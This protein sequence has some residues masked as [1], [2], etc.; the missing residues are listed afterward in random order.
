MGDVIK[1]RDKYEAL[2]TLTLH[3]F[4]NCDLPEYKIKLANDLSHLAER[5]SGI[6]R[7]SGLDLCRRYESDAETQTSSRKAPSARRWGKWISR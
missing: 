1:M 6:V 5:W 3:K 2:R 4:K 7:C